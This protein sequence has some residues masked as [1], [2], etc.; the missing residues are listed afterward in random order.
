MLQGW[1]CGSNKLFSEKREEEGKRVRTV[2]RSWSGIEMVIRRIEKRENVNRGKSKTF[3]IFWRI[4]HSQDQYLLWDKNEED[5]F[6]DDIFM[7]VVEIY[8]C[9]GVAVFFFFFFKNFK[10]KKKFFFYL[11]FLFFCFFFFFLHRSIIHAYNFLGNFKVYLSFFF[12]LFFFAQL[13]GCAAFTAD[14]ALNA[15]ISVE[16]INTWVKSNYDYISA[17]FVE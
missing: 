1:W 10:K 3:Y 12:F 4:L 6:D 16:G 9:P 8:F 14:T 5:C 15:W 17:D 7:W 2:R 13:A 11:F